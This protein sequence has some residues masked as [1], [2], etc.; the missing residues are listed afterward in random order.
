MKKTKDLTII[1]VLLLII[2]ALLLFFS[3]HAYLHYSALKHHRDY[4]REPEHPIQP[5]M[6]VPTIAHEYNIP[7]DALYNE[8]GI[9]NNALNSM[10]TLQQICTENHLDCMAEVDKLNQLT[11]NA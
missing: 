6:T 7:E 5:W 1:W 11:H 9:K 4:F 8:L 3:Y 2:I 10:K